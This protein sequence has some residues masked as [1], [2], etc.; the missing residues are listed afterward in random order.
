M[1][2]FMPV[3]IFNLCNLTYC[4]PLNFVNEKVEFLR[5]N[6]R[7]P[8]IQTEGIDMAISRT[9]TRQNMTH[10]HIIVNLNTSI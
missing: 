5:G 6:E 2:A 10:I 3:I 7:K 1:V 8:T 9:I 4:I